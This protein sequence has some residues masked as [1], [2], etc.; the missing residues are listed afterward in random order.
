[1]TFLQMPSLRWK[2]DFDFRERQEY[3][4]IR[5]V[6]DALLENTLKKKVLV[7][8]R[9]LHW[10]RAL[11]CLDSETFQKISSFGYSKRE[12]LSS[13]EVLICFHIRQKYHHSPSTM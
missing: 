11:I 3:F 12:E 6:D 10:K 7:V 8:G 5:K 4:L 9:S 1:M 13:Q 2:S